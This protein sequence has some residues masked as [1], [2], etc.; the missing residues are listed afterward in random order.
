MIRGPSVLLPGVDFHAS[1]KYHPELPGPSTWGPTAASLMKNESEMESPK[2]A[3]MDP[4]MVQ[5]FEKDHQTD[6]EKEILAVIESKNPEVDSIES[7]WHSL[8]RKVMIAADGWTREPKML[9]YLQQCAADLFARMYFREF[10]TNLE[11]EEYIE[12]GSKAI[13]AQMRIELSG[14][15][16]WSCVYKGMEWRVYDEFGDPEEASPPNEAEPVDIARLSR[17]IKFLN[18]P[19]NLSGTAV[20]PHGGS[21]PTS[22]GVHNPPLPNIN[23]RLPV[24][25]RPPIVRENPRP[26]DPLAPLTPSRVGGFTAA[27]EVPKKTPIRLKIRIPQR[28]PPPPTGPLAHPPREE[29]AD[30]PTMPSLPPSRGVVETPEIP[31]LTGE[32]PRPSRGAP[33]TSFSGGV[34]TQPTIIATPGTR[35]L[36]HLPFFLRFLTLRCDRSDK[37]WRTLCTDVYADYAFW[38]PKA[39][40]PTMG[41]IQIGTELGK[42]GIYSKPFNRRRYYVGIKLKYLVA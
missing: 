10:T 1:R 13:L 17:T 26:T 31:E 12:Q 29:R 25:T 40:A 32:V 20:T 36:E 4:D 42:Y 8:Q 6:F 41:K 34:P 23:C 24:L 22:G 5:L 16:V 7:R 14:L 28:Q 15:K 33:R 27:V 2:S 19:W 21:H 38:A 35:G 11:N 37:L 3:D 30:D 9:P 18:K 39:N